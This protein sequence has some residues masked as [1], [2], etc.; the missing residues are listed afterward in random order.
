MSVIM[1]SG[2][3]WA[4]AYHTCSCGVWDQAPIDPHH[5]E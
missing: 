5:V 1:L 2:L 4:L 3:M